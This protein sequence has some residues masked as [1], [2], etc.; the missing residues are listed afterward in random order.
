LAG[1]KGVLLLASEQQ[2]T[3]WGAFI[4]RLKGNDPTPKPEEPWWTR[5]YPY[6]HTTQA[7][8]RYM[9]RYG[10]DHIIPL[11]ERA[12]AVGFTNWKAVRELI[13]KHAATAQAR[14]SIQEARAH[15]HRAEQPH[16]AVDVEDDED[17]EAEDC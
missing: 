8:W 9:H 4:E 15:L 3:N 2:F 16:I 10:C 12:Y 17:D 13:E 1:I 7:V 14:Q 5:G 11:F 6:E